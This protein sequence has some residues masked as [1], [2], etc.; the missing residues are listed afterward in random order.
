M[1]EGLLEFSEFDP[2]AEAVSAEPVGVDPAFSF[3][4]PFAETDPAS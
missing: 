3:V 2:E 1:N 4:D